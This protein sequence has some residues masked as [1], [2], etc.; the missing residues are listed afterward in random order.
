MLGVRV[1]MTSFHI[2]YSTND[3]L[4]EFVSAWHGSARSSQSGCR[5][6]YGVVACCCVV[7]YNMIHLSLS[8]RIKCVDELA[9]TDVSNNDI[10]LSFCD[11]LQCRSIKLWAQI[12]FGTLY[13]WS[14]MIW[15]MSLSYIDCRN[16]WSYWSLLCCNRS[17]WKVHENVYAVI[18]RLVTSVTWGVS[19]GYL[20]LMI[21]LGE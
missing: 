20:C 4:W 13:H 10:L 1:V 19:T 17:L 3:L 5:G 11:V 15:T 18:A 9:G 7:C 8:R 16:T 2:L 12:V 14:Q 6:Q 21:I